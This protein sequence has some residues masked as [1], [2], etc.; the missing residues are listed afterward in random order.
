[1]MNTTILPRD[2]EVGFLSHIS[3]DHR[4][5]FIEMVETLDLNRGTSAPLN[6]F[7]AVSILR[8]LSQM[9]VDQED[10]LR[11]PAQRILL[12]ILGSHLEPYFSAF[13]EIETYH[14]ASHLMDRVLKKSASFDDLNNSASLQLLL[15]WLMQTDRTKSI[16]NQGEREKVRGQILSIVESKLESRDLIS[17]SATSSYQY[18]FHLLAIAFRETGHPDAM[19][20]IRQVIAETVDAGVLTMALIALREVAENPR[21]P[22]FEIFSLRQMQRVRWMGYERINALFLPLLESHQLA[23]GPQSDLLSDLM[24][25]IMMQASWEGKALIF[26]KFEETH[27]ANSARL[28]LFLRLL[29]IEL[30]KHQAPI[31]VLNE[32]RSPNHWMDHLK[33]TLYLAIEFVP[34]I[35]FHDPEILSELRRFLV[36]DRHLE[37]APYEK[38]EA[39]RTE[40]PHELTQNKVWSDLVQTFLTYEA[41]VAQKSGRADSAMSHDCNVILL[42]SKHSARSGAMSSDH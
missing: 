2:L 7:M 39:G 15:L 42:E 38:R 29:I 16:L 30:K 34:R 24:V 8:F 10:N 13:G 22:E 40:L 19:G 35:G 26:A 37:F 4:R 14:F 17:A 21:A 41:S 11:A 12:E 6:R 33:E 36:D 5:R 31:F 3:S 32:E 9:L 20:L 28:R 1:M 23:D 27:S 25:A 18:L